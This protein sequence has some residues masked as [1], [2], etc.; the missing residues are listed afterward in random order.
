MRVLGMGAPEL[1]LMVPFLLAAGVAIFAIVMAVRLVRAAE[2][3]AA[4][5][6][7]IASEMARRS[8]TPGNG[9]Q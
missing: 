3:T 9:N 8:T 5:T 2:R 6:E 1:L 4:A 7:A